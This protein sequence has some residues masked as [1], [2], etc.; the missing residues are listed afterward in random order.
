MIVD[1]SRRLNILRRTINDEEIVL[2]CVLALANEG[3]R[4]LE[5]DIAQRASDIDVVYRNGYGFPA[6]R[7][8]PMFAIDEMGVTRAIQAME[9]FSAGY[10]GKFWDV[11]PLIRRCAA[12]SMAV[13]NQ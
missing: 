4:L 3:A 5:E 10:Q 12:S 11:A 7:G 2:R 8:G 1:H 6:S 13:S 9:Q